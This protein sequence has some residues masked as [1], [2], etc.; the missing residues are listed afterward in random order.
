MQDLVSIVN[1]VGFPIAAF[2][3][4]FWQNT[5]IIKSNSEAMQEIK[6]AIQ[7]IRVALEGK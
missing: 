7:E 1:S 5:T 4:M 3:L 6:T 2:L